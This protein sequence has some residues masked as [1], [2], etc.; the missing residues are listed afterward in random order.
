MTFHPHRGSRLACWPLG[1]A[2][3]VP[4][5]YGEAECDAGILSI[6][7]CSSDPG[8]ED[9]EAGESS[10]QHTADDEPGGSPGD[11]SD[12]LRRRP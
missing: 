11:H 4:G 8:G 2:F 1:M 10:C 7:S 12:P 9:V 6:M 3:S 5:G